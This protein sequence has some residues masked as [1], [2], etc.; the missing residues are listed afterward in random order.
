MCSKQKYQITA[1]KNRNILSPFSST[2]VRWD[3]CQER[4]YSAFDA[5][6]MTKVSTE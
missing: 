2:T 1:F 5:E 6:R 4:N 3:M